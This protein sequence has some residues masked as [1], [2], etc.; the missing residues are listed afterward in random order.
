[1][2]NLRVSYLNISPYS[3]HSPIQI[4]T[5]LKKQSNSVERPKSSKNQYPPG[6]TT[7]GQTAL[8]SPEVLIDKKTLSPLA[9]RKGDLM[10]SLY[11]LAKSRQLKEKPGTAGITGSSKLYKP[12]DLQGKKV[13]NDNSRPP[14]NEKLAIYQYL[15]NK[16]SKRS[17]ES[18]IMLQHTLSRTGSKSL[19]QDEKDQSHERKMHEG[20]IL[21]QRQLIEALEDVQKSK[22]KPRPTTQTNLALLLKSTQKTPSS[23]TMTKGLS[24]ISSPLSVSA[25]NKEYEERKRLNH[26]SSKDLFKDLKMSMNFQDA[27]EYREKHYIKPPVDKEAAVKKHHRRGLSSG[28]NPVYMD[29]QVMMEQAA[30]EQEREKQKQLLM[31]QQQ[32]LQMQFQMQQQLQLQQQQQQ[33]QQLQ[34]QQQQ[35]QQYAQ[36]DEDDYYEEFFHMDRMTF[37][38]EKFTL[39]QRLSRQQSFTPTASPKNK[40]KATF[41]GRT[42]SIEEPSSLLPTKSSSRWTTKRSSMGEDYLQHHRVEGGGATREHFHLIEQTSDLD[43]TDEKEKYYKM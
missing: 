33:Q 30:A 7:R 41:H 12:R 26:Q 13:I 43:K 8:N 19:F 22:S 32:Q 36:Q 34:Q 25:V 4:K 23:S 17:E 21:Q 20:S 27:P 24:L 14:V 2:N 39:A 10:A 28:Q 35:Q 6:S 29:Q 5:E 40:P 38:F 1:M 9:D 18:N 11:H 31:F 37:D 15:Q 3:R 42:R 16:G